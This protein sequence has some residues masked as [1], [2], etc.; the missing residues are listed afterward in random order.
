MSVFQC[1]LT[2]QYSTIVLAFLPISS[3]FSHVIKKNI[4]TRKQDKSKFI[5]QFTELIQVI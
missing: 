1:S 4:S 3:T 5:I 2:A